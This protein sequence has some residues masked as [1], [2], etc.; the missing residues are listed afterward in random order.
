MGILIGEVGVGPALAGMA[1]LAVLVPIQN[2]LSG[3]IGNLRRAMVKHTDN[4]VMLINEILQAIRIIKLYAWEAPME[5]RVRQCRKSELK[6]LSSYLNINGWLRELLFVVQPLAVMT[7]FLTSLYAYNRPLEQVQIIKVI[8]F[9]TIT[10]FPL[11]L[12]GVA[13]KSLK[14]GSVS[15]QRLQRYLLLPV[16][17]SQRDSAQIVPEP[18]IC[19]S[20][21][22]LSCPKRP[23]LWS[24]RKVSTPE[25]TPRSPPPRRGTSN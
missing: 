8:S 7:I 1:V 16:L 12:L 21:A 22:V 4:R 13:L 11:N 15:L 6:E 3:T 10:R 25:A 24:S 23:P 17:N 18:K 2:N 14:D 19:I 5:Q 20:N 9:L